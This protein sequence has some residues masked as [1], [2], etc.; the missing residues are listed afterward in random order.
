MTFINKYDI[1][2]HFQG[3]ELCVDHL[4]AIRIHFTIYVN[5]RKTG[6]GMEVVVLFVF[7]CIMKGESRTKWLHTQ[8]KYTMQVYYLL[9]R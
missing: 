8:H 6:N 1:D 5:G 2:K 7:R 9:L 3:T 4:K